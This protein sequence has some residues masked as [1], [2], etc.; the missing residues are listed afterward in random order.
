L[1]VAAEFALVAV[2]RS[3]VDN[4]AEAG[5]RRARSVRALLRRLSFHLSGAQLGITV[6][7]LVVGFLAEPTIGR[8]LEPAL[9]PLVGERAT[10]GVSLAVA[11]AIVTVVQMVVAEMVPKGLAI[12]RPDEVSR[13]LAP[14]ISAYGSVF[15]PVIR[16]LNGAANWTV[17]RL[18]MEPT[19]E[20][21]EVRTL[22]ELDLL[23]AN[24]SDQGTIGG[25]ASRLLA[26]SIRFGRKTAADAL[27]P[28]PDVVAIPIDATAQELVDVSART[29]HSRMP[30]TGADIDD[31]RGVVH[32][33]AVHRVPHAERST[34]R[35][36]SF[37]DDPLVV[38]ESRELD[39]VLADMRSARQHLVVVLDEYGGTAGIVTLE[40]IVEEIVGE[41]DDEYDSRTPELT[42]P[43]AAHEWVLPGGLHL[44]E[45][46]EACGL[47]VPEGGY[48]TLAGFVLDRL[49]HIPVEGEHVE[50]DG[51][52]LEVVTMDRR[53]IAEIR[54][55]R[56]E[57]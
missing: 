22:A 34:V 17:R 37:M 19:E 57:P 43:F 44:D 53:R 25:S 42:I 55:D 46:D 2:D 31:V 13:W 45:V 32:V 26:R 49:G 21:S 41:I 54:V 24:S 8:L 6:T 3:R 10:R 30:V 20:L 56:A 12:A 15:G 50:L 29:G 39:D 1:F 28:R 5:S 51:W 14:I 38:P 33:R 9:E 27:V 18:G 16:I 11:L 47:R 40:D 48:D 4:D 35:V 23:I 7:S 52:T 36:E